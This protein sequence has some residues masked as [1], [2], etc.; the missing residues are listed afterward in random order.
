MRPAKP[1][2]RTTT[3]TPQPAKKDPATEAIASLTRERDLIG[4]VTEEEKARWEIAKGSYKH[5]TSKQKEKIILLAREID[6]LSELSNQQTE[7]GQAVDS[8]VK[9][10]DLIRA[11]TEEEK[12]RWEIEKGAY[13]NFSDAL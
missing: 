7:G 5:F 13:R 3:K 6:S 9:E 1:P 12:I 8:M 10:R 11:A 2:T 4:A